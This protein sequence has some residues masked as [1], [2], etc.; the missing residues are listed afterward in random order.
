[1]VNMLD[2]ELERFGENTDLTVVKPTG[3]LPGDVMITAVTA[4]GVNGLVLALRRGRRKRV[5]KPLAS[6]DLVAKLIFGGEHQLLRVD[7][8]GAIDVPRSLCQQTPMLPMGI[9]LVIGASTIFDGPCRERRLN[10][11]P[12]PAAPA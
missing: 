5:I 11:D 1:M 8:V 6:S 10:R 3:T 7:T 4:V 12:C 9:L 2:V